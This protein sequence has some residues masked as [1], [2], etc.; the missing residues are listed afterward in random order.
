MESVA[1]TVQRRL[2][3][4]FHAGVHRRRATKVATAFLAQAG[5]QVAGP[6]VTVHRL[7]GG[8]QAEPLLC[9]FVGLDFG[10]HRSVNRLVIVRKTAKQ[11]PLRD[12]GG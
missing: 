1:V 2:D 8:R 4:L 10:A 5:R 6:G 9:P 12:R 7:S 3:G 11:N